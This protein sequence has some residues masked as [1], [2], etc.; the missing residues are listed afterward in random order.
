[1]TL[2]GQA[3]SA[4]LTRFEIK[5]T[6]MMV[7]LLYKE[8]KRQTDTQTDADKS[9]TRVAA[10]LPINSPANVINPG[11]VDGRRERRLVAGIQRFVDNWLRARKRVEEL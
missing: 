2:T 6:V 1:M 11:A 4:A 5:S 9:S 3:G 7:P 8:T 10:H